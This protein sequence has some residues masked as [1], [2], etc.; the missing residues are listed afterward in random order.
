MDIQAINLFIG[1]ILRFCQNSE[2]SLWWIVRQIAEEY[3]ENARGF[4][5]DEIINLFFA[6]H[7]PKRILLSLL[8]AIETIIVETAEMEL[9]VH[10]FFG[11]SDFQENHFYG[12]N[13]IHAIEFPLD[14]GILESE[15]AFQPSEMFS[16]ARLGSAQRLRRTLETIR[17]NL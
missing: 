15:T 17:G 4:D 10:Q 2:P 9:Q 1:Y 13:F 11:T 7:E 16:D 14:H 12:D 3:A 6:Q 8:Q 5:D